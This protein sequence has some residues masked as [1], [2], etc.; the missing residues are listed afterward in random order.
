MRKKN[1]HE[2]LHFHLHNREEDVQEKIAK[3]EFHQALLLEMIGETN[4]PFYKLVIEAGLSKEEME[5]VF[6][7]C[8]TLTK[9]FEE[10][11]EY[12]F[13]YFSSLLTD[14]AGMLNPKLDVK[15]TINALY[16]QKL[17]VPL[18]ER[19]LVLLKETEH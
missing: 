9:I 8:E 15:K 2:S 11:K 18:M 13:V 10:Q 14:F 7:L 19:L 1:E 5:D 17:Y 4:Y 12:G 16:N 6:Q 3:L